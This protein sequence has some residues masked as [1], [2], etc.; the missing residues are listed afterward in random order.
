[1]PALRA[2]VFPGA[3]NLPLYL[4]A[5]IELLYTR[6]RDEQIR[7]IQA[8]DADVIHTSPDNLRLDD[9]RG[10]VAFLGGSTGALSL[11]AANASA[12]PHTLAVDNRSSGFGVL[13]Y[14]WL[15]RNRPE[16][17]YDIIEVGGTALRFEAL[18]SGRATMAV[19]AAPFTQQCDMLHYVNL[20]RIDEG[21]VTLCGAYRPDRLSAEQTAQYREQYR[22]ALD[23]L[24][25][26]DGDAVA[27]RVLREHTDLPPDIVDAV[28]REMRESVV[29]AGVNYS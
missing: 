5:G 27:E 6:S 12:G 13:A 14:D 28:A 7:T 21:R 9:A 18:K 3:H 8:G 20:G 4:M 10:L 25:G 1:M 2:M 24:A 22:A 29:S 19:M 26:P 11:V 15:A 23:I 16:W 17:K